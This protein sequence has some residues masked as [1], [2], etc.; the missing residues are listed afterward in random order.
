MACCDVREC[1]WFWGWK[2]NGNEDDDWEDHD[3]DI[4]EVEEFMPDGHLLRWNCTASVQCSYLGNPTSPQAK[5]CF[6]HH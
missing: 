1:G 6:E 2:G 3:D 4:D 5:R